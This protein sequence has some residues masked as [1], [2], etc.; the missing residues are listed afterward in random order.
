[1]M[2]GLRARRVT[3]FASNLHFFTAG[4][5]APITAILFAVADGAFTGLV[6]ALAFFLTHRF[7][8]QSGIPGL[9]LFRAV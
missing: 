7:L 4:I 9:S 3:A 6:G 2:M 8:L 1:M 5:L